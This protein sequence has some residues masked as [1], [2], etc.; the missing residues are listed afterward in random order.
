[1]ILSPLVLPAGNN[2]DISVDVN[3]VINIP[4]ESGSVA[5]Y[6]SDNEIIDLGDQLLETK[7]FVEFTGLGNQTI[8]SVI[9]IP[10]ST[11]PGNKYI[12][13][14]LDPDNIIEES[15]EANNILSAIIKIEDRSG[16]DNWKI[17]NILVYPNPSSGLFY[18]RNIES[19]SEKIQI[20]VLNISGSLVYNKTIY[21]GNTV[22]TEEINI[23]GESKGVYFIHIQIGRLEYS[24]RI[25]VM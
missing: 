3:N 1:L 9:K 18:I 12:I 2:V 14:I 4:A 10:E 7:N 13:L 21:P 19:N 16:T 24:K 11:V 6:L 5:F 22:F 25:V 17:N 8:N 20:Q 15:D 23:S